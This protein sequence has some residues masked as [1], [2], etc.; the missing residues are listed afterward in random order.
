M[1]LRLLAGLNRLF[2]TLTMVG[3]RHRDAEMSTQRG[4]AERLQDNLM[5]HHQSIRTI[6]LAL[7][8]CYLTL[9]FPTSESGKQMAREIRRAASD[10][11]DLRLA[12]NCCGAAD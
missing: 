9:T 5:I 11:E 10:S 3:E 2:D 6:Y 4:V 1:R 8:R 12:E 7:V